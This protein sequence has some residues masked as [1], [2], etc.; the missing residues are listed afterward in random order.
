LL[1]PFIQVCAGFGPLLVLSLLTGVQASGC[2]YLKQQQQENVNVNTHRQLQTRTRNGDGGIPEGGYSAVKE[3]IKIILTDSKE[4]FPAD[5]EP[6]VGPNYGGLMIRLAWHCS[7]SYRESD[8]RGGC[9]GAR[10]RF[11]PELNWEDNHNL[12]NARKL[13]E[14]IKEKYGSKLSWGDLII[15]AGNAAIESMGGPIF[16]FCGGRIDDI[17][18]SDSLVLGPSDEQEAISACQSLERSMQGA[19][20][21]VDG[22]P[23]GPSTVGLIYVDAAGPRDRR[24]TP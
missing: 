16:G 2:P 13:L 6:P 12:N 9:D 24:A 3:D 1:S 23:I 18:G 14:P 22:S 17:D 5:F 7:G 15:L 19:C 21:L 11:D 20:N 10:I 8:G 4:F